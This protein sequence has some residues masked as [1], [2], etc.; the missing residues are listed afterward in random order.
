MWEIHTRSIGKKIHCSV[1]DGQNFTL[2]ISFYVSYLVQAAVSV[3]CLPLPLE[4][5]NDKADEDVDHKEGEDDD[6]DHV[7]EEDVSP[8]VEDR[9]LVL[10]I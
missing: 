9:P 2:F 1:K 8:V 7:E 10:R 6:V 4:G 5:D 3:R